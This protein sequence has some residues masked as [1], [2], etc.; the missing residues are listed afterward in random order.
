MGAWT[1]RLP[2]PHMQSSYFALYAVIGAS[3][4]VAAAA[5]RLIGRLG[6]VVARVDPMR[7]I[8]PET[9]GAVP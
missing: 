6:P 1:D 7:E 4:I 3:M 8:S 5:P 9:M 2:A